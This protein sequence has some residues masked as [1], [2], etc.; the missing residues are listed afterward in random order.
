MQLSKNLRLG[1]R[2]EEK[3]KARTSEEKKQIKLDKDKAEEKYMWATMNGKR[4][5]VG[6]FRVEPPGLFTVEA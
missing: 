3:V 4:E 6:N 1:S 5:Q 2:E